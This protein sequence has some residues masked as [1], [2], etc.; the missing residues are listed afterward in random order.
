MYLSA[1]LIAI[2][3]CL[4]GVVVNAKSPVSVVA[5]VRG[6][7]Y[8]IT[9]ETVGDFSE[10]VE[11][12]AG[13]EAGQQSVLFRGK[14]LEASDKL[15]DLGVNKGDVLNVLKGR[16]PRVA[17]PDGDAELDSVDMGSDSLTSA[18]PED[19]M[20]MSPEEQQATLENLDPEIKQ[21]IQQQSMQQLDAMLDQDLDSLFGDE[22]KME[23]NRQQM[24]AN[25]DQYSN[26]PGFEQMK[27]KALEIASSPEKWREAMTAAKEQFVKLR[28]ERDRIRGGGAPSGSSDSGVDDIGDEE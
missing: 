18:L 20:N 10:Q 26:M 15:E 28:E 4:I 12:L 21:K 5:N 6:K 25:I 23:A 7:K 16:K 22:E 9:A 24:L 14:V 8:D 2:A 11:S 19:F 17:K 3:I 13:L 1:L 27:D